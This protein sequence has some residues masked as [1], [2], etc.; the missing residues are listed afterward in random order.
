MRVEEVMYLI[1]VFGHFFLE[2]IRFVLC[3]ILDEV[4]IRKVLGYFCDHVMMCC[5]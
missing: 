3:T 1:R 5:D 2:R 4:L